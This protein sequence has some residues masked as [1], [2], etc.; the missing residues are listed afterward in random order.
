[1]FSNLAYLKNLKLEENHVNKKEENSFKRLFKLKHL[2][3][4]YNCLKKLH[5]KLFKD[6][7]NLTWISLSHNHITGI[8]NLFHNNLEL[9]HIDLSNYQIKSV[10]SKTGQS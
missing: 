10:T 6:L 8:D 2:D 9:N 7:I 1:M 4:S 3:M 5:N